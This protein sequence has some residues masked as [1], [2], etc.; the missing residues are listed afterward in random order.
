M[1]VSTAGKSRNSSTQP[2]NEEPQSSQNST[3]VGRVV[4]LHSILRPNALFVGVVDVKLILSPNTSNCE[5]VTA[6]FM[7]DSSINPADT[8]LQV[9]HS[10]VDELEE[11]EA[12]VIGVMFDGERKENPPDFWETN[13]LPI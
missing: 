11:P 13:D 4:G 9:L 7:F 5:V 8:I 12:P 3:R 10:M 2:A 6:T 1:C